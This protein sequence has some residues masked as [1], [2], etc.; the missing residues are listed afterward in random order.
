M[1]RAAEER[2]QRRADRRQEKRDSRRQERVAK[3]MN[4]VRTRLEMDRTT[5]IETILAQTRAAKEQME[6][7][8]DDLERQADAEEPLLS[9]ESADGAHGITAWE[10][11]GEPVPSSKGSSSWFFWGGGG[12][13]AAAGGR[14][15]AQGRIN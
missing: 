3:H 5:S 6:D 7:D 13:K 1:H 14:A 10:H 4:G 11:T 2:Q 12:K 8:G 15:G 9:E